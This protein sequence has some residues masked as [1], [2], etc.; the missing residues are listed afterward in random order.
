MKML[1]TLFCFLPSFVPQAQTQNK[2]PISLQKPKAKPTVEK[3]TMEYT[4]RIYN[5]CVPEYVN[6]TGTVTY[7]I[8]QT[9]TDNRYF[10]LYRIDLRQITGE[11]EKSG[12]K[13]KGGG[14][15][16]DKVNA[17]YRAN[18]TEGSDHYKVRYRSPSSQ[19]VFNQNAHF[20][21][22]NGEQKV[23]FNDVD[24]HCDTGKNTKH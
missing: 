13:Y 16:M 15:I 12:E 18:H 21:V 22:A 17:N 24:D 3:Y 4:S 20:V 2:A 5:E 23:S 11:G 6:L 9:Q 7:S 10:I 8:R 14:V 19:L 1:F